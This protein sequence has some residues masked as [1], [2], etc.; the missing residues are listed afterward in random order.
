MAF[1]F[2]GHFDTMQDE[3]PQKVHAG[4]IDVMFGIRGAVYGFTDKLIRVMYE[5]K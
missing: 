2:L 4:D 3:Y 1:K 5:L